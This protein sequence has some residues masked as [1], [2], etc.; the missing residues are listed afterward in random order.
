MRELLLL[1]CCAWSA[2]GAPIIPGVYTGTLQFG[3]A[4]FED[5]RTL[6]R[7]PGDMVGVGTAIVNLGTV[8]LRLSSI[9]FTGTI[10][11]NTFPVTGVEFTNGHKFYEILMPG[12]A[13]LGF[14]TSYFQ[15]VYPATVSPNALPNG[16]GVVYFN[17]SP[18]TILSGSLNVNYNLELSGAVIDAQATHL[19]GEV[20][21]A[22]AGFVVSNAVDG[23]TME[24]TVEDTVPEPSTLT[25]AA[26]GLGALLVKIIARPSAR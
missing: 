3:F 13:S 25:M 19:H 4:Y 2:H 21:F 8:P 18:V 12:E 10:T 15:A 14:Q 23:Y 17:D 11:N 24:I 20:E 5:F 26:L 6:A 16:M 9:L 1:A 22:S 7:V